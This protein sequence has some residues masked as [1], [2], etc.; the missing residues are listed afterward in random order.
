MPQ[1]RRCGTTGGSQ[2][3]WKNRNEYPTRIPRP[4]SGARSLMNDVWLRYVVFVRLYPVNVTTCAAC[5]LGQVYEAC[6]FR[7]E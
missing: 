7:T 3:S 2:I 4:I 6:T 5:C 1:R